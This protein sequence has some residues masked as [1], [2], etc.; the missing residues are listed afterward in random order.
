M[1]PLTRHV[2]LRWMQRI[3]KELRC[4]VCGV[5][6]GQLHD[7]PWHMLVESGFTRLMS[8]RVYTDVTPPPCD[9]ATVLT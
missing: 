7:E 2:V 4:S 3:S 8:E 9:F 1:N 6:P 5:G